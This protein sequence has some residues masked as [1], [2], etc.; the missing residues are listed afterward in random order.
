MW[1]GRPFG[2]LAEDGPLRVEAERLDELRLHALEQR[3][4]ADLSLGRAA[5]IVDEVEAAVSQYPYRERLWRVLMLAL[6]HSGRQADALAAYRRARTMLDEQLGIDPSAA[7]QALEGQILRQEV[8]LIARSERR[9][10]LPNPLNSFVG[11]ERE[12]RELAG[13]VASHRLVTLTGVGWRRQDPTGDRGLSTDRGN[14][15]RWRRIRGS[16]TDHR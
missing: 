3:F 14:C 10:H 13:L 8:P 6:Y 11:R 15:A 4:E 1:R 2:D 9:E 5:E 12:V 16:G 7:L